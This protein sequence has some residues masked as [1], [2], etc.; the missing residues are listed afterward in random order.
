[1]VEGATKREGK[2][3]GG[4]ASEGEMSRGLTRHEGKGKNGGDRKSSKRSRVE[5]GRRGRG[6]G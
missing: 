5:G 6:A 1:M 2:G 3:E 4:G